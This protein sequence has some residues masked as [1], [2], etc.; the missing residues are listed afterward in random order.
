MKQ[1]MFMSRSEFK[2]NIPNITDSYAVISL[3]D[4]AKEQQEIAQKTGEKCPILAL[5]VKDNDIDFSNEQAEE[6]CKFVHAN[7][8]KLFLIHCF[9]GVSRSAAVARWIEFELYGELSPRLKN[10]SVYNKHI[11]NVLNKG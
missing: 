11:F 5:V 6:I 2:R 10:Y 4:T 8:D 9:A 1:V 3:N 7:K